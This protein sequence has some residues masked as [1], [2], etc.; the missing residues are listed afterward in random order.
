MTARKSSIWLKAD[1][2]HLSHILAILNGRQNHLRSSA[3]GGV[4][5]MGSAEGCMGVETGLGKTRRAAATAVQT[6]EP[7]K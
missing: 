6:V 5:T 4:V 7:G 3:M 2:K 1:I